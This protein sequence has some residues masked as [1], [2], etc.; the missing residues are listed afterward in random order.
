M[1]KVLSVLFAVV[2]AC[3]LMYV[4]PTQ[5]NYEDQDKIAYNIAYKSATTFADSVRNKGYITPKM[6]T[7]FN[8]ELSATDNIYDIQMEH[9]RKRY[10]PIYTD[11]AN[12]ATFQG[13]F[14]VYY[15]G[16]YTDKIMSTLFPTNSLPVTDTSRKYYLQ[17]GD[18]FYVTI[19]NK[20]FTKATL[21]SDFLTNSN[22][23]DPTRI[24]IP[25]GGMVNNEDY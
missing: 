13:K 14:E 8:N 10:N 23:G 24:Y 11:P 25:Y 6:Y 9:D 20:N 4:W 1:A 12:P 15:D 2:V 3:G 19:K 7:D 5:N 17:S 16:F 21:V 18:Y 22:T